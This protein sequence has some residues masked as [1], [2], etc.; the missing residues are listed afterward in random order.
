VTTAVVLILLVGAS[1]MYLG[2]HYLSDVAGGFLAGGVWLA[3][4]VIACELAESRQ[5][6]PIR[7]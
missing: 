6:V 7:S 4:C 5:S 2:V 1:R 3:I